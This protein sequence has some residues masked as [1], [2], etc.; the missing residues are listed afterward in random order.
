MYVE[1]AYKTSSYKI[2]EAHKVYHAVS[3]LFLIKGSGFGE[4]GHPHLEFSGVPPREIIARY[5]KRE[6]KEIFSQRLINI[7]FSPSISYFL[8]N[9]RNDNH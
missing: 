4:P 1:I 6:K 8:S 7:Q 9:Q 5:E 2:A 3:V